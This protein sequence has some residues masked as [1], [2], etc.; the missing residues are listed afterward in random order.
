MST[1]VFGSEALFSVC[2]W[3]GTAGLEGA[4]SLIVSWESAGSEV[5]SEKSAFVDGATAA[6][7]TPLVWETALA[8]GSSGSAATGATEAG[9]A[10]SRTSDSCDSTTGGTVD[11]AVVS[12]I[13]VSI[14]SSCTESA[15]RSGAGLET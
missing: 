14:A 7:D 1:S 13:D 8:D 11:S 5:G 4:S 12:S 2:S 6:G 10:A 15:D 3:S 9:G